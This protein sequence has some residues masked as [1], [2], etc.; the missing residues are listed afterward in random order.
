MR[1]TAN[2]FLVAALAIAGAALAADKER[3]GEEIVKQQCSQCHATGAHGAPRIDDRAAWVPRMKNGLDATVRSAIRGHG[4][5][6]ARGGMANLTDNELRSAIVYMFNT[7]GPGTP[8]PPKAEPGPNQ[9]IVDGMDIF[10]GVKPVKEGLAHVNITVRDDKTQAPVDDAQVEVTITNP[11]M[12]TESGKLRSAGAK[13]GSYGADF[14]MSGTEPHTITVR[15]RRPN[16]RATQ[17]QFIY[18]G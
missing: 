1:T 9:K 14:R 2:L 10:L 5:M 16:Q 6:P 12:G 4:Q 7:A 13:S 17:A 3:T 15:I 8:P 11:V 18:K